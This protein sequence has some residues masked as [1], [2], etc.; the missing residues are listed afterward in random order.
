MSTRSP[1]S[2]TTL[3]H[4][5]SEQHPDSL[6]QTRG[7]SGHDR[8]LHPGRRVTTNPP[9]NPGRFRVCEAGGALLPRARGA[10]VIPL[11]SAIRRLSI[12]G[13]PA[14]LRASFHTAAPQVWVAT[15]YTLSPT[16]S[17]INVLVLDP[18]RSPGSTPVQLRERA[19]GGGASCGVGVLNHPDKRGDGT[20]ATRL[21]SRYSADVLLR[22]PRMRRTR[23]VRGPVCV[24]QG[25]VDVVRIDWPPQQPPLD[26]N[27][28]RPS[29]AP[30]LWPQPY[31][32]RVNST[33]SGTRSGPPAG[34]GR[35]GWG[36]SNP[37]C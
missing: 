3:R 15:A 17:A 37:A 2:L 8:G 19:S 28:Q 18:R 31:A 7:E 32:S 33:N 1:T 20:G 22:T 26:R 14:A 30:K 27:T 35:S 9:T 4:D 13:Q 16:N 34:T 6:H 23:G 36:G 5:P 21:P 11:C 24:G 29:T 12:A 25:V 10:G